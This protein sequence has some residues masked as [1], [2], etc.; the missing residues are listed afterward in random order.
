MRALKRALS[1]VLLAA[2]LLVSHAPDVRA[3]WREDGTALCTA[4]GE[5][6]DQKAVSDGGGG[7][8]VAWLDRRS[9]AYQIYA[10]RVDVLGVV[11]WEKNGVPLCPRSKD[12]GEFTIAPDGTGGAIVTWYDP[13]GKYPRIL[14]QRVDASGAVPWGSHGEE[15]Y[16]PV[17]TRQRPTIASDG[18]G[19]AIVTWYVEDGM[20]FFILAQR[21]D[22][23]GV[24]R[25][26]SGGVTLCT[27]AGVEGDPVIAP[28]G[29]GGAIVAWQDAGHGD[30]S[31]DIRAQR[32]DAWGTL[33][34]AGDGV[35]L[36][37]A[38]GDQSSPT[39]MSDG[40]GGAVVAWE[41]ARVAKHA[42]IYAQ[43]V[44]ASGEVLWA[45]NGVSVSVSTHR[46]SQPVISPDGAGGAIF[47]W[48][49]EQ[50]RYEDIY[51]QRMDAS[52]AIQWG[53]EGLTVC[54]SKGDQGSP[55]IVSDGEGGAIIAWHD[56][57]RFS[58][59]IYAQRVDA[60]GEFQW[61]LD[62]LAL[63]KAI[64]DQ[65]EPQI[66][67]DG[68]G[69]GIVAWCDDRR[70]ET[71][72]YA[73]RVTCDGQ[74]G[75]PPPLEATIDLD[76]ETLNKKSKGKATTCYIELPEGYDPT[77]IDVST[78]TL[79]S[80]LNA[81]LTPTTVG[82][83]DADGVA[84]RMVKFNRSTV[85]ALLAGTKGIRLWLTERGDDAWPF[86]HGTEFEMTV[87]GKL[88]DGTLFSGMDVIRAINPGGGQSA[89]GSGDYVAA[90]LYPT[91]VERAPKISYEL[92]AEGVISL[93]VF[94]AAGRLVRTLEEG[95]RPAGFH[96]VT[97]DGR[98]DDG[99]KA[100]AGLYFIRL[101]Q[102]SRA[103]VQKLLLLE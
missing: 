64:R 24:T 1:L 70:A 57:R 102:R 83:H 96:T 62:G 27:N 95:L 12:L 35:P 51:A 81:E 36:C 78:V 39:I 29:V 61:T 32:V 85:I 69:G 56:D 72:I 103:R 75:P 21:L 98:T 59:D 33:Q 84:D 28:D 65:R 42:D 89:V 54:A 49:E 44:D 48:T 46:K 90:K 97:W 22:A 77:D 38:A 23:S 94:D 14:A 47:A 30:G 13:A 31:R 37:M 100:R 17:D 20:D 74:V 40:T 86:K 8:I 66:F 50:K 18:A 15:V 71:D 82:D 6:Y 53:G 68:A 58:R 79:N 55:T 91:T 16:G 3:K 93:R 52:G 101:E 34:W 10:Q 26:A 92:T 41:D 5:Q 9:G 11:Q 43:Q 7:A 19:G 88:T 67:T 80:E 73:Q 63:C 25:W 4:E 76:P 87:S 2:V 99:R 45:A 60:S